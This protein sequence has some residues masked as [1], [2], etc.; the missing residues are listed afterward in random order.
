M[1]GSNGLNRIKSYSKSGDCVN[2][3]KT[4]SDW[5]NAFKEALEYI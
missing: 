5:I 4:S 3:C 2:G 1:M